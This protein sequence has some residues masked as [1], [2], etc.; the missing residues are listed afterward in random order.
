MINQ[1]VRLS[2][3]HKTLLARIDQVLAE[4]QWSDRHWSISATNGADAIR[5]IRNGKS[6]SPR[7]DT[8]MKLAHAAGVSVEWLT[9]ESAETSAQGFNEEIFTP[10]IPSNS[11]RLALIGY[12]GAGDRVYHFGIG[13]SRLS[14]EAPAGIVRGAAAEVRGQSMLP[15]YRDGDLV[16]GKE[17]LGDIEEMVGRDCFVQVEDGALFL[18]ILRRG[19]KGRFSLE[20]YN[21]ATA[22]ISNQPVEWIAPVAWVKRK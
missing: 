22:L 4:K 18:K 3:Q 8:L 1:M 5:N 7:I 20:S 19:T 16:I 6:K 12:I 17:H 13:E 2:A 21:P 11:G 10:P 14:V 15:V 9:G